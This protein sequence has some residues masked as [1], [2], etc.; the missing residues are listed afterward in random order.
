[1]PGARPNY[2]ERKNKF[3]SEHSPV[4]HLEVHVDFGG[5]LKLLLAVLDRVTDLNRFEDIK[6]LSKVIGEGILRNNNAFH[7]M[8]G[9]G[10]CYSLDS[11]SAMQY[12]QEPMD[13]LV[14]F[15]KMPV[16]GG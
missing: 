10:Q 3:L 2:T 15:S 9:I 4:T 11:I 16:V 12:D 1:M 5:V 7:F 6:G 13:F 14:T 8:S